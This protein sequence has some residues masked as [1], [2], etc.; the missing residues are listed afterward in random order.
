MTGGE[1]AHGPGRWGD[2][3]RFA[4]LVAALVMAA[5][6]LSAP[7]VPAAA[8]EDSDSGSHPWLR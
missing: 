2:P 7:P 1:L 8:S 5:L 4:F 6:M 3:A